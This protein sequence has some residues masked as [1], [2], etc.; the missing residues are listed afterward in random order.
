[1]SPD[2]VYLLPDL[3]GWI[4]HG[5]YLEEEGGVPMIN[6]DPNFNHREMVKS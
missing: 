3:V 4:R 6:P 1:M 5:Q 2:L